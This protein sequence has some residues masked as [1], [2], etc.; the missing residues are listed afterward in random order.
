MQESSILSRAGRPS[1]RACG[2]C[3]PARSFGARPR[4]GRDGGAEGSAI[5]GTAHPGGWVSAIPHRGLLHGPDTP[6]GRHLR[7]ANLPPRRA[8]YRRVGP[9]RPGRWRVRRGVIATIV[10]VAC[11]LALPA[12]ADQWSKSYPVSDHPG[13]WVSTGDGSVTIGVWDNPQVEARIETVGYQI[14]KDF[15]LIEGLSGNQVRIE[16]KFP[17]GKWTVGVGRRSLTLTVMVPRTTNLDLHSGDGSI[18]VSGAAGD[19]KFHTGDGSIEGR[20]LDGRLA[21]STG[22][23]SVKVEGRFD[24]LDLHTGDGSIEAAAKEGSALAAS[25]SIRTGDGSV[26]LRVPPDLKANIDARTGDGRV[27]LDLPVAVSGSLRPTHV[28]GTINGGGGLLMI[29]TGDGSIH[30]ARY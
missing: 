17:E 23:G 20:N 14:N 29:R 8:V 24:L 9:I 4:S 6:S 10:A 28:T 27:T 5:R 21:A 12:S 26:T 11:G 2:W 22:D 7:P 19:H 25:W 16:L 15:Q 13:L 18:T 1:R 30:L 3:F